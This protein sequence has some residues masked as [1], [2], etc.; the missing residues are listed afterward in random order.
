MMADVS[1]L[2]SLALIKWVMP[3]YLVSVYLQNGLI[4]FHF[5]KNYL[6]PMANI[7]RNSSLLRFDLLMDIWALDYDK[8]NNPFRF[9]LNYNFLSLY[10]C[11]RVIFFTTIRNALRGRHGLFAYWIESISSVYASSKWLER[12]VWD[13]FGIFCERQ[14]ELDRILSDYGFKGFPLRKDFPLAGYTQV[15][16]DESLNKIMCEPVYFTHA[17]RFYQFPSPWPGGNPEELAR[18]KHNHDIL[19]ELEGKKGWYPV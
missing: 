7:L 3:K 10:Q 18:I 4:F 2:Y 19:M 17:Y 1:I 12:E 6:I 11:I 8:N 16:Y 14:F 13:M 9:K 15:Y 5:D